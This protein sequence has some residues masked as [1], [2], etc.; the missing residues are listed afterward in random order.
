MKRL[1]AFIIAIL[2]IYAIF[3]DLTSGT[4]P[5]QNVTPAIEASAANQKASL[6]FFEK[7]VGPGETVL[8]IIETQLGAPIPVAIDTV[9]ND[10]QSLNNGIQPEQIQNGKTYKFPSYQ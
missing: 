6:E 5:N 7:K 3:V 4:L 10:F 2:C 8:T 9:I 1:S